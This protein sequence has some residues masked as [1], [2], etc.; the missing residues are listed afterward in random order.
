M[1]LD[2]T[3]LCQPRSLMF[4]GS[5]LDQSIATSFLFVVKNLVN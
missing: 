4:Y 5:G 2:L 3:R 1:N